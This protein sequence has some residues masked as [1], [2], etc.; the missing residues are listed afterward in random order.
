MKERIFLSELPDNLQRKIIVCLQSNN[1][2]LAKKMFDDYKSTNGL[3]RK[4]HKVKH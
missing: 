4:V 1:F 2:G 3:I